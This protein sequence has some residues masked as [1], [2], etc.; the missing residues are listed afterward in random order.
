MDPVSIDDDLELFSG[1]FHQFGPHGSAFLRIHFDFDFP[2]GYVW[3][4]PLGQIAPEACDQSRRFYFQLSDSHLSAMAPRVFLV[5]ALKGK[6]PFVSSPTQPR[7]LVVTD[8]VGP[9]V[10]VG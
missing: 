6:L 8:G 10:S 1:P 5:L 9:P 3:S 4:E 7:G 2:G